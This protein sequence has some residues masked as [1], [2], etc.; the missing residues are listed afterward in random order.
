MKDFISIIIYWLLPSN[1][2]TMAN[3]FHNRII[4]IIYLSS[5]FSFVKWVNHI[6]IWFSEKG[7]LLLKR[8][9]IYKPY[10]LC[11]KFW[12]G[13]ISCIITSKVPNPVIRK[14]NLQCFQDSFEF[15]SERQPFIL[16]GIW[17]SSCTRNRLPT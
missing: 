3:N 15:Y 11:R 10:N 5:T 8:R 4:M 2:K 13:S 12:N 6:D 9:S 1:P 14:I 16:V 7:N 17:M